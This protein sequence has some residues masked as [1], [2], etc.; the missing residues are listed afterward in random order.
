MSLVLPRIDDEDVGGSKVGGVAGHQVEAVTERGGSNEAI[1]C[2]DHY[3]REVCGSRERA[4]DLAGFEVDG[5]DAIG[6]EAL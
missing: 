1:T 3:T 2:W 4:P 6:I 5:K